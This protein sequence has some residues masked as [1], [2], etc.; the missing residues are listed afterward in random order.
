MQSPVFQAFLFL[1]ALGQRYS[2]A[3]E[4]GTYVDYVSCDFL[5]NGK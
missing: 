2:D 4:I 3:L 5:P 1:G